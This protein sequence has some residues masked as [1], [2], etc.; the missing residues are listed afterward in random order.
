MTNLTNTKVAAEL[1]ELTSKMH[2]VEVSCNYQNNL[3]LFGKIENVQK[4]VK[5][6]CANGLAALLNEIP[7]TNNPY[8]DGH[9]S[10]I[11]GRI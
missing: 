9:M 1:N 8:F 11:V 10:A 5:E 2:G 3:V 6:L 4:V 7:S